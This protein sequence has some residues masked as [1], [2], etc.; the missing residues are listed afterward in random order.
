MKTGDIVTADILNIPFV[1]HR[2]I[3]MTNEFNE[4][5]FYHNTPTKKNKFGGNIICENYIDFLKGRKIIK[6][7]STNIKKSDILK[8]VSE[9]KNR[10]FNLLGF[11][12]YDF[13]NYIKNK[14]LQNKNKCLNLSIQKT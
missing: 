1:I 13:I 6:I 4:P 9:C 11:N 8:A 12:C 2:A 7:E 14:K 3:V 5:I 10:K